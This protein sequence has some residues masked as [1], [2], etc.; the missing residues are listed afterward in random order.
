MNFK[1][2]MAAKR[3]ADSRTRIAD[4]G[5]YEVL[6]ENN[7]TKTLLGFVFG[8]LKEIDWNVAKKW[9]E[10]NLSYMED[11]DKFK[12]RLASFIAN[13]FI[14]SEK[15]DLLQEAGLNLGERA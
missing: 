11:N 13:N 8:N 10:N 6:A 7:D 12:E 9:F 3:V 1:R 4:S 2:L 5:L 15:T 14:Q